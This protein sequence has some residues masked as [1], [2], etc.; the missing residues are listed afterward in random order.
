MLTY[1][2]RRLQDALL[3]TIALLM[4]L[5]IAT[6]AKANPE[7]VCQNSVPLLISRSADAPKAV[8]ILIHGFG[9]HK[10]A[11]EDFAQEMKKRNISTYALDVRGFGDWQV[12]CPY[13]ALNFEYALQDIDKT[14][15]L[16]RNRYPAS[17]IYLVGE[18]MGGTLALAYAARY[19]GRIDGVVASVPAYTRAYALPTTLWVATRYLL[20][21]GGTINMNKSLVGRA[22]SDRLVQNTWRQDK[23]ARLRFSLSELMRFNRFMKRADR[24]ARSISDTSV[25]LL[26]GEQDRLIK[27]RGTTKIF[28]ELPTPDKE[29]AMFNSEEHLILEERPVSKNVMARIEKWINEHQ[30]SKVVA[31]I[32]K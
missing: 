26:Q 13:R 18:S 14:V 31:S 28:E 1:V 21:A 23:E 32:D 30:N 19:D 15:S 25:L 20:G 27:P 12:N 24:Y 3:I 2:K 8:A 16:I 22:S 4:Q 6:A 7:P 10:G 11:Y 17:S 5:L 29:L 9:L